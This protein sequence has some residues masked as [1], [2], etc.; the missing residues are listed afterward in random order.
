MSTTYIPLRNDSGIRSLSKN[1]RDFVR[2]CALSTPVLRVD[3]RKQGELRKVRW[4]LKRWDNGAEC[5]VQWGAG[6]RVS[7]TCSADLV[8]PSPDRPNEGIVQIAVDVSPMA[9]TTF[10]L[11]PPKSTAPLQT[12]VSSNHAD[13]EQKLLTNRILRC[14]ERVILTGGAL[15]TEALVLVS[16]KWAWRLSISL[17]LLDHGGN[18]TDA[19]VLAAMAALRHYRKPQ[20]EMGANEDE[21]ETSTSTVLPSILSATVKEPTPLPLHHTPL[22]VS[23]ALIPSNDGTSI[24]QALVDPSDR[25]ELVQ[26]GS[27]TV[28]MN[29]HTEV[30]LLDYGGGCELNPDKLKECFETS[31]GVVRE[32]CSQLE[33]ALKNADEEAQT[34]QLKRVKQQSQIA[35][36][37]MDLDETP[38]DSAA[39]GEEAAS[40]DVEMDASAMAEEEAYRRKALDYSSGHVASSVR[41][42]KPQ[43]SKSSTSGS[44]LASFLKS[45]KAPAV[46][47]TK[48][49][50]TP[51]LPPPAAKK[52][53]AVD[54]AAMS[55]SDNEETT[56]TML[57]SEFQPVEAKTG[58]GESKGK[59]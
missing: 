13:T 51:V 17:T 58:S 47:E 8:P 6:T 45:A 18:L 59:K 43:Q 49:K 21:A 46:A 27:L 32:L 54:D 11:A 57:Q 26:D 2:S 23:F 12:G 40:N 25:E 16:G 56:T 41:E 29:I 1:E 42:D 37:F 38:Q 55:D 5:T 48:K 19:C 20:V 35:M 31:T 34:E 53:S 3:G 30:C 10:R 4:S 33:E 9:G 44:L 36:D 52:A 24:V 50:E 14:L 28:A 39:G 22:S 15:D 7:A